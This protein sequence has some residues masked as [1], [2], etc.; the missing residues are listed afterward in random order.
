MP[1]EQP[2]GDRVDEVVRTVQIKRAGDVA[3]CM[4]YD[5][6]YDVASLRIVNCTDTGEMDHWEVVYISTDLFFLRHRATQLC[7]P[8]N[9]EHPGSPFGCFDHSGAD[10]AL[11]DSVNGLVE[12]SSAFVA[13][14]GFIDPFN[15]MYI[16]NSV[17][18]DGNT[19]GADDDVV[20]M[21]YN[22]AGDHLVLF[23]EKILLDMPDIVAFY[24]LS[25]SWMFS[26]ITTGG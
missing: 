23:G 1:T 24:E 17:C 20:F 16:Y 25:A 21:T 15:S 5:D 14:L 13:E 12:C 4:G 6:S 22:N 10:S 3:E 19:P 9:P 7:I 26:D 18:S 8:E 11:A 2:Y